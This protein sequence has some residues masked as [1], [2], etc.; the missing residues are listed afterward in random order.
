MLA[1]GSW[2]SVCLEETC[3]QNKTTEFVIRLDV[4]FIDRGSASYR[5]ILFYN[6]VT[7]I[8]LFKLGDRNLTDKFSMMYT[9]LK[10][11]CSKNIQQQFRQTGANRNI[12]VHM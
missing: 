1:V 9:I 3:V 5:W 10:N 11:L 12:T 4:E 8:T 2:A 7:S 6:R